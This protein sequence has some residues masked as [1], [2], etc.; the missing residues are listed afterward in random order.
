M[1]GKKTRERILDASLKLF[2]QKQASNVST[3]QISAY[4]KISPGNLYYYFANKEEL[5]QCIW[6]ER[7]KEEFVGLMELLPKMERAEDLSGF[8]DRCFAHYERYR[9]FYTEMP[10]LFV[11]DKALALLYR[12]TAERMEIALEDLFT[13]WREAGLMKGPEA[14]PG[15]RMLAKNCLALSYYGE[16]ERMLG[17]LMPYLTEEACGAPAGRMGYSG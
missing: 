12:E 17:L 11:N 10:T 15:D 13:R 14:V 16:K 8:F 9:F 4:M 7:I 6:R 3:V 2:N 5:I 1:K